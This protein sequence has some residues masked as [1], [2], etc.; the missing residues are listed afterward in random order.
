[1]FNIEVLICEL[2]AINGFAASAVS[3][4]EITTLQH[5]VWNYTVEFGSSI[6]IVLTGG[7]VL[8]SAELTEILGS[9]GD[10]IIIELEDDTTSIRAVNFDIELCKMGSMQAPGLDRCLRWGPIRVQIDKRSSWP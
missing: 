9:S 10:D 3:A 5:E 1:V 7:G 4:G 2:L 6:T 8:A